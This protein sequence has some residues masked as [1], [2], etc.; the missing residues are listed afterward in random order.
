MLGI[1]RYLSSDTLFKNPWVTL[2]GK[3]ISTADIVRLR[4]EYN[5]YLSG[6][7]AASKPCSLQPQNSVK[8]KTPI[9]TSTP[10]K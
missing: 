7:K 10:N 5:Q 1:G 3:K 6:S 2:E 8:P 9:T 4:Q